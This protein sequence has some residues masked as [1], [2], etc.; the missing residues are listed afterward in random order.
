MGW[1]TFIV[2][3]ALNPRRKASLADALGGAADALIQSATDFEHEV[4]N[5]IQR[6]KSE[7]Q[8]VDIEEVRGQIRRRRKAR[9]AKGKGLDL[10][11]IKVAQKKTLAGEPVNYAAIEREILDQYKPFP[12]GKVMFWLFFPESI[13]A[14]KAFKYLKSKVSIKPK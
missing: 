6:L 1:G 14:R 9:R 11:I 7:G 4:L 10:A 2:G 5:E 3:R 8:S 13:W 12:W